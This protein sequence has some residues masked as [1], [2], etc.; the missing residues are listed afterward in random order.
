[1]KNSITLS[2]LFILLTLVSCNKEKAI[3][4]ELKKVAADIN[5]TTPQ[6]LA[7]RVRLDSV[8][9]KP[10]KIFKYNYTLTDDIK[11]NVSPEDIE[12]FKTQTKEGALKVIK[13]S[14]EIKEFRD[15]DVTMEYLYYDKN[16]KPIADFTITPTEYKVK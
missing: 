9:A 8:S 13:T 5:K 12:T 15:N 14:G 4:D 7:D 10:G 11:E 1:M 6:N 2:V 16:G 3:E